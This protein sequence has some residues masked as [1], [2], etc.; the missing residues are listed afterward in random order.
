VKGVEVQ[1]LLNKRRGKLT[2]QSLPP[3]MSAVDLGLGKHCFPV[4]PTI[5][6]FFLNH[7]LIQS[8]KNSIHKKT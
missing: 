5:F 7:P 3:N 2:R 6:D 8:S 4:V 1:K